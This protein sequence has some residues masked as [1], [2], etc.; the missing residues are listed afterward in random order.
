MV[1]RS[2]MPLGLPAPGAVKRLAVTGVTGW[3]GRQS[4]G[5]RLRET[6][7]GTLTTR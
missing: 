4:W 6:G 1:A 5:Y 2:F 3:D 7:T